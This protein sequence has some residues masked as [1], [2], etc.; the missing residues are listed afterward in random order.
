MLW[1]SPS[2]LH[3]AGGNLSD[4]YHSERQF[5]GSVDT[6]IEFYNTKRPTAHSTTGHRTNLSAACTKER[7]GQLIWTKGSKWNIFRFQHQAYDFSSLQYG[8]WA[9]HEE[10]LKYQG[11]LP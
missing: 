11:F 3:E 10:S 7:I 4:Q 5:M 6:Y 9:V 2:L 1:P 8:N